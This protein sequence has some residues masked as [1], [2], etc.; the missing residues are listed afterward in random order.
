[1]LCLKVLIALALTFPAYG[2]YEANWGYHGETGPEYWATLYPNSDCDGKKQSPIEFSIVN[3]EYRSFDP[4][5]LTNLVPVHEVRMHL[6]NNGHT[7]MVH[8]NGSEEIAGGGLENTYIAEQFHFHWGSDDSVGSE[9]LID[10][11]QYPAEL[12]IV[13]YD[14]DR[15]RSIGEALT[16]PKGLAVLGFFFKIDGNNENEAFQPLVDLIDKVP[17]EGNSVE[18]RAPFKVNSLLPT[19]LD[20]YFRYDGSLTT[21][22]CYESVVWTVFNEPIKVSRNQ[23][24]AFRNVYE[25]NNYQ[26][27][28]E[29]VLLVDNHR[30]TQPINDRIVYRSFPTAGARQTEASSRHL[31]FC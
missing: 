6:E 31:C 10:G 27:G 29:P 5:V 22:D 7:L 28:L 16:Q 18:F 23:I 4:L 13:H 11:R 19:K 14:S 26:D 21:P 24:Q 12:H 1:M 3:T 9:H 17:L 8:L 20:D 15:F 2:E 30:P 25:K